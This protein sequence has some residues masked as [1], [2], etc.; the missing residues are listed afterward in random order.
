MKLLERIFGK[1]KKTETMVSESHSA[2]EVEP[3]KTKRIFLIWDEISINGDE[4]CEAFLRTNRIS[5]ENA[6]KLDVSFE[7][8]Y[9]EN[10]LIEIY[11]RTNVRLPHS[12]DG[13]EYKEYPIHQILRISCNQNG[14]HQLGGKLPSEMNFPEN[15]CKVPFQY[16]GYINHLDENFDWLESTIHLMCPIYL[17]ID[18][19]FLDYSNS[20]K[21]ILLNKNEV[22]IC[23]TVYDGLNEKTI[24]EFESR[25]FDLIPSDEYSW[26]QSG[27]PLF[28]QSTNIPKCPKS[29]KFMRFL[30]QMSGG[31]SVSNAKLKED[32]LNKYVG[33]LNFWGDGN[34]YVFVEPNEKT[35]CYFIQIT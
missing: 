20:S 19:V 17:N 5:E 25:K 23:G 6:K 14:K 24:V 16:L 12:P 11:E 3:E 30:C 31:T 28:L 15:N 7:L 18:K 29:G 22:E 35:I 33:D 4:D 34:L 8:V 32:Y 21:P 13:L 1:S 10:K 9:H 2:P 26:G 27:A